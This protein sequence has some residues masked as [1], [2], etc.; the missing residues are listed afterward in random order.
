[1]APKYIKTREEKKT[2][3]D[4]DQNPPSKTKPKIRKIKPIR[5]SHQE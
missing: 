1:M 5:V 4:K 3:E 2:M